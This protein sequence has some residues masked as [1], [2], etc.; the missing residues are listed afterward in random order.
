MTHRAVCTLAG[1][2][3]IQASSQLTPEPDQRWRG[4]RDNRCK[5]IHMSQLLWQRS[6]LT[7]AQLLSHD[8]ATIEQQAAQVPTSAPV[9]DNG[10]APTVDRPVS[11]RARPYTPRGS[12]NNY[13]GYSSQ[14]K[15][16][17]H[18]V[19]TRQVPDWADAGVD[20]EDSASASGRSPLANKDNHGVNDAAGSGRRPFYERQCA[21][22]LLL[23]N[24]AEGTTHADITESIRGGQLLDIHLRPHERTAS[25]SFL[26]AASARAFFDHVRR[27]DLYIRHKRVSQAVELP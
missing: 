6:I 13:G 16:F 22:S 11:P 26:L 7:H 8:D 17:S 4:R 27:H 15:T 5:L 9:E 3:L 10:F 12:S 2:P 23:S 14:P 20:E 25:V 21:R 18:R 24:L 1:H 19:H